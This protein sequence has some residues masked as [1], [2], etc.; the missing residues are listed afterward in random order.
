MSIFGVKTSDS[1]REKKPTLKQFLKTTA[2]SKYRSDGVVEIVWLPG[3]FKNIT[4]Q[5]DSFRV[6]ISETHVFYE[7]LKKILGNIGENTNGFRVEISDWKSGE[8]ILHELSDDEGHWEHVGD[9][10]LR[11]VAA[12]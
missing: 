2:K 6:L 11:F 5:T 4:L 8:Y 10:G 9:K 12:N 1:K 7:P 3:Q